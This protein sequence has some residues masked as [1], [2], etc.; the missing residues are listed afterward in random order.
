MD[1]STLYFS[2]RGNLVKA[3]FF[4]ALAGAAIAIIAILLPQP[5]GGPQ[6][7]QL[8][9]GGLVLPM[10][11]PRPDPFAGLKIPILVV[12]VGYAIFL[13]GRH[14]MRAA[15]GEVAVKIDAGK[16]HFHPSYISAADILPIDD[17]MSVIV[18]RADRLPNGESLKLLRVYSGSSFRAAQWG[19]KLRHGLYMQYRSAG[20][21]GAVRVM[22]NDVDGG[23][24]QLRRFAAQLEVWRQSPSRTAS[25]Y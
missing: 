17:I 3:L 6:P 9:P 10:P 24:E 4:L 2:T 14:A 23:T 16:L 5:H 13:A 18:D 21:A 1:P 11:A 7:T 15:S 8:L 19:A 12:A 20:T 22:D 25:R